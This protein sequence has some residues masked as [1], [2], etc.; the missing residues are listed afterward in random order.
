MLWDIV[1]KLLAENINDMVADKPNA[2]DHIKDALG[3]IVDVYGDTEEAY[4]ISTEILPILY[5]LYL[6]T[7]STWDHDLQI[8]VTIEKI[9]K[10]TIKYYGDLTTFINSLIWDHGCVPHYWLE[11]SEES[12]YDTSEWSQCS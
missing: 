5:F 2:F 12:G 3:N 6:W 8:R 7:Y 11:Y 4:R 10:F 9:N 1:Y